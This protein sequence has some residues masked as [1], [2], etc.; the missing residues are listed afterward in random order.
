MK[1]LTKYEQMPKKARCMEAE[2]GWW[3]ADQSGINV[4]AQ[5]DGVITRVRITRGQIEKYV[6]KMGSSTLRNK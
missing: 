1:E 3:Y 6:K 2:A 5:R 4:L